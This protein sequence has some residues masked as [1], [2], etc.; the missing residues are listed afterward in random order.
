MARERATG[1]KQQFKHLLL[2]DGKRSN[3][4]LYKTLRVKVLTLV[5]SRD[6]EKNVHPQGNTKEKSH[7]ELEHAK[8]TGQK[9]L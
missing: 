7:S 1:S 9:K 8:L 6:N 2:T 4:D 3:R 5:L